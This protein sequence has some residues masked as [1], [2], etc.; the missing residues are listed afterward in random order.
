[1]EGVGGIRVSCVYIGWWGRGSVGLG[2]S[3]GLGCGRGRGVRAGSVGP[4][5][6]RG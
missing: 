6:A 2:W 3:V 4:A 1:M 5:D